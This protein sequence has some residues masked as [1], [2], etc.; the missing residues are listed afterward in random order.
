ME[1]QESEKIKPPRRKGG[2]PRIEGKQ[3]EFL[4]TWSDYYLIM[5]AAAWNQR[6]LPEFMR[7]IVYDLRKRL[8]YDMAFKD[9]CQRHKE[10]L[11]E[12]GIDVEAIF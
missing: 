1:N 2:R 9:Y 7:S 5:A 4:T 11:R 6:E 3:V 8:R 10:E 12:K